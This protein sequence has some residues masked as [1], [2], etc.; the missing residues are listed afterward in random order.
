MNPGRSLAGIG[1]A[2]AFAVLSII[3]GGADIV[4][5]GHASVVSIPLLVFAGVA[6]AL[7]GL[8]PR[9]GASAFLILLATLILVPGTVA[10]VG[11]LC[12]GIYAVAAL[13]IYKG[14]YIS[15][16]LAIVG[17]GAI[18]IPGPYVRAGFL[19]LAIGTFLSVLVGFGGRRF[20]ARL[21]TADVALA[22]EQERS[23]SMIVDARQAT[24]QILHDTAVANLVKAIAA[25]EQALSIASDPH[26]AG[27]L[28]DAL[29]ATRTAMADLRFVID[30]THA[31]ILS[32]SPE[33]LDDVVRDSERT[34]AIHGIVLE[35]DID[36]TLV[37][38]L[39]AEERALLLTLVREGCINI[40]KYAPRGSTASLIVERA[41]D[42]GPASIEVTL[43]NEIGPSGSADASN[44]LGLSGLAR[45]ASALGA[46]VG[47]HV[48]AGRWVLSAR[49]PLAHVEAEDAR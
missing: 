30:T 1:G 35:T 10:S 28:R 29:D 43:V 47:A 27:Q 6:F 42:D 37:R 7:T 32:P 48:I 24:A 26:L 44:G 38:Q 46:N 12:F 34:L 41:S 17:Y 4:A 9:A 2:S 31:P 39:D 19:E 36:D 3:L 23:H 14:W 15:A 45:R 8:F 21:R 49:I 13:W 5:Y 16:L 11:L 22:L 40:F 20:A 18:H 25:Q 33:S